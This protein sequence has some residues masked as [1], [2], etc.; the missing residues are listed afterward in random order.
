MKGPMCH[1][2]L[3]SVFSREGV[4]INLEIVHDIEALFT[5]EFPWTCQDEIP[6]FNARTSLSSKR[7][8]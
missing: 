4:P 3:L 8:L 1:L 7:I 6:V 5:A 2:A